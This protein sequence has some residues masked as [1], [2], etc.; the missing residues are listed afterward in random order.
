VLTFTP[1]PNANGSTQ[2][3]IQLKDSG[4]T[5]NNGQNTST[6]LLGAIEIQPVNDPPVAVA[7]MLSTAEDTG[8]TIAVQTNDEDIDGDPLATLIVMAPAHGV[9]T[10]NVDG[11]ISYLPAMDYNG[12]DSFTYQVRDPDGLTSATVSVTLTITPVNDAPRPGDDM[13]TVAQNTPKVIDPLANDVDV[14]GDAMTITAVSTP[15]HGAVTIAADGKSLTYTPTN[16]YS[17]PD[18]ITY[19]VTDS[20]GASATG[21][22][23]LDVVRMNRAPEFVAPTPMAALTAQEAQQLSFTLAATDADMDPLTYTIDPMPAGATLNAT[24]GAF[25]WT[26]TWEQAGPLM[27]TLRVSDGEA[28]TTLALSIAVSF[29]DMDMDGL[30]DTW[31]LTRGLSTSSADSD[32]DTISD[33]EEVGPDLQ[34]PRDTDGDNILDALEE[35][36]DNDGTPDALEAGDADLATPPLN[37]DGDDKPDYRDTDSDDDGVPDVR[38]NCRLVSNFDQRDENNDGLG[39][40]CSMDTDGDGLPDSVEI[41]RGLNPMS[42]DSDGDTIPDGVEFGPITMPL[43][44]DGDM[45]IDALDDDSD[46]DGLLDSEEAG[47]ADLTTPP[48]DTDND[49]KPDY[50][51]TDSDA[52]SVS[53]DMDNCPFKRN[54]DQA[55]TDGDGVGDVC[56]AD[57]DGDGVDSAMDNCPDDANPEQTDTD[58]D[59]DGDACDLDRDGDTIPNVQDSCP[60]LASPNQLDTDSDGAGDACD[61][62]DD[63]DGVADAVDNCPLVNNIDQSDADADGLGD[64]CDPTPNP[65]AAEDE[66]CGCVT[67]S[68]QRRAL[69]RVPSLLSALGLL[70]LL[71]WRRKRRAC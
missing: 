55:D 34:N 28:E 67:V 40:V 57:A 19:T 38:D 36:A 56:S 70:G 68:G 18:Q 22:I 59:G 14:E 2:L 41:Q 21:L 7:D 35:D 58:G 64:V 25:A 15:D 29:I 6:T 23:G 5:T 37:T 42:A 20:N 17:G 33:L 3:Q 46:G 49:G 71:G 60:D 39:D 10:A 52:D 45:T 13:V 12:A 53:D 69:P 27:L 9:A 1:K 66:G 48:R 51:D 24:S 43:D 26:P 31:E 54:R 62:D 4:G 8:A 47:D 11:T 50:R 65:P 30:P 61:D 63:N 44:T 32:G 16:L